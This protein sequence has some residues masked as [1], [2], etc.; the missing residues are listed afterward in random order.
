MAR[1]LKKNRKKF[2]LIANLEK[3]RLNLLSHWKQTR[4]DKV[5][6]TIIDK[7]MRD[8]SEPSDSCDCSSVLSRGNFRLPCQVG[9]V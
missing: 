2:V 4:N 9:R 3:Q 5:L 1:Y 7:T 8:S 6:K